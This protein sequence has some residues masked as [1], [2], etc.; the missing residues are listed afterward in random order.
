MGQYWGPSVGGRQSLAGQQAPERDIEKHTKRTSSPPQKNC[1]AGY[2]NAFVVRKITYHR[3]YVLASLVTAFA[4]TG[5][6]KRIIPKT[7]AVGAGKNGS[8]GVVV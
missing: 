1:R 6:K 3:N 8:S 5:R 2:G 4:A 7:L